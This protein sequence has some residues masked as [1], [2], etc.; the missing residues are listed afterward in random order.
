MNFFQ[1]SLPF[2][3][4][5]VSLSKFLAS[6]A[7][8]SPSSFSSPP[9]T[10]RH[11]DT[12]SKGNSP[13]VTSQNIGE[14][15]TEASSTDEHTTDDATASPGGRSSRKR[16]WRK[17]PDHQHA[18]H[19]SNRDSYNNQQDNDDRRDSNRRSANK[20]RKNGLDRRWNKEHDEGE[21]T[22]NQ[23]R[24]TPRNRKWND[25]NSNRGNRNHGQMNRSNE[26]HNNAESSW[27]GGV[28]WN[29]PPPPMPPRHQVPQSSPAMNMCTNRFTME[30][31]LQQNQALQPHV[32]AVFPGMMAAQP[33]MTMISQASAI[34]NMLPPQPLQAMNALNVV[35]P[36]NQNSP[37]ISPMSNQQ[38]NPATIPSSASQAPPP[39]P[40]VVG[41]TSGQFNTPAANT[42]DVT[43][44]NMVNQLLLLNAE[45]LKQTQGGASHSG[46][47]DNH[48][49]SSPASPPHRSG[50]S[51]SRSRTTSSLP[52]H[53]K[54][55]TDADGR[56]YYYH[57]V[58]RLVLNFSFCSSI[59]FFSML[60]Y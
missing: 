42:P 20:D 24:W 4:R 3:Y 22:R 11:V 49:N 8:S 53:W 26:Q 27:N 1:C 36:N 47:P 15:V 58:T 25:W 17:S 6:T 14:H 45:R 10:T 30:N 28:H 21:S 29:H 13:F 50:S 35:L 9:A 39:F 7:S 33:P 55:A 16:E 23:N 2:V 46:T 40:T 44:L 56:V 43:T 12:S 5:N 48:R 41:S 19:H 54:T 59:D 18:R 32:Q 60:F 34:P 57:T 31:S 51:P 37:L 38:Y 52:P